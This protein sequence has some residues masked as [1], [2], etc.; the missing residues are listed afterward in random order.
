MAADGHLLVGTTGDREP[1]GQDEG[2]PAEDLASPFATSITA[3]HEDLVL[4]G[5]R[6]EE[7]LPVIDPRRG[8]FGRDHDQF[9]PRQCQGAHEFRIPYVI[10][11]GDRRRDAH[12]IEKKGALPRLEI[13]GFVQKGEQVGFV[14]VPHDLP[15]I[16]DEEGPVVQL[17][18]RLH[19]GQTSTGKEEPLVSTGTVIISQGEGLTGRALNPALS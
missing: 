19:P 5:P 1:S 17:A 14:I 12:E 11:N 3:D 15:R 2:P 10:T 9:S 18:G 7:G 8:P 6:S 13:Q 16:P 4:D